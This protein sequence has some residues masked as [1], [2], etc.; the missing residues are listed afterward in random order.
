MPQELSNNLKSIHGSTLSTW[1]ESSNAPGTGW[2]ETEQGSRAL[3]LI[4]G[5]VLPSILA[6]VIRAALPLESIPRSPP[7]EAV[8]VIGA[9]I[10]ALGEDLKTPASAEAPV[11]VLASTATAVRLVTEWLTITIFTTFLAFFF[12]ITS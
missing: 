11:E 1:E 3:F 9:K 12:V 7:P 6:V 4:E 2:P 8:R 5:R 10:P